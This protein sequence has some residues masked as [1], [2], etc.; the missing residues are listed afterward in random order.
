M[1]ER[2][3]SPSF[4]FLTVDIT[5]RRSIPLA[6]YSA[7]LGSFTSIDGEL[8]ANILIV[9]SSNAPV[10]LV[11]IDTLFVDGE[12][13]EALARSIGIDPDRLLLVA[14]HT[15]NA[16]ALCRSTPALGAVD[17]EYF[18]NC[19][20]KI[21]DAVRG[22]LSVR[23]ARL[24]IAS[25]TFSGKYAV[26]RRRLSWVLSYGELRKGHLPKLERRIALARNRR[27]FSDNTLRVWAFF[28]VSG[29]VE[30]IIWSIAAHPAFYPAADVVSPDF[31]G[32]VRSH[33]RSRFG[34]DLPIFFL[35]GFAGSAIPDFPSA[36]PSTLK[37]LVSA[38]LPF[39]PLLPHQSMKGYA[40]YC[41]NLL[42]D[43]VASFRT[44]NAP[45]D[46][47]SV[48]M[49][50]IQS[51]AIFFDKTGAEVSLRLFALGFAGLGSIFISSGEL[52]SEWLPLLDVGNTSIA[53]GYGV[54]RPLYVP[55]SAQIEDGG[56]EVEGFQLPFGL[57]G[58]FAADIDDS[59]KRSFARILCRVAAE[60]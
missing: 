21:S 7:R 16:P 51:P 60:M 12:F 13:H 33:L 6:G 57:N 54:G 52:V 44:M 18:E 17:P 31:P 47:S 43:I 4:R 10:I 15:H 42:H 35:P 8:E 19:I 38:C 32:T 34:K 28:S 25:S 58:N 22:N 45:M 27:G 20:E 29:A 36:F 49:E 2:L 3:N 1:V 26:S 46:C 55:T 50:G 11:T 53:T 40:D 37:Q 23:S 48:V 24:K 39:H 14:S 9:I 41:T 56:Y 59:V 5:P 30:A